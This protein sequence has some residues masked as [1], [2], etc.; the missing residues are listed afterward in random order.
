MK[1][2]SIIQWQISLGHYDWSQIDLAF[3]KKINE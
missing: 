1:T 3:A 2:A